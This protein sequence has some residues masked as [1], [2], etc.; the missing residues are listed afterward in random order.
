MAA[1]VGPD[2][3]NIHGTEDVNVYGWY[4]RLNLQPP[5]KVRRPEI[6]NHFTGWMS[7]TVIWPFSFMAMN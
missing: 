7:V 1:S 3:R 4:V 2:W 5:R 6:K